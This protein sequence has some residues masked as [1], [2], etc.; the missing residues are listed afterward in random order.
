MLKKFLPKASQ[1]KDDKKLFYPTTSS[2]I[3]FIN[4]FPA[5]KESF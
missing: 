3:M 2:Q 4:T 5:Q 1:N